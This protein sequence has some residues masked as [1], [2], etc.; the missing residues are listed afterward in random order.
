M[1]DGKKFLSRTGFY[2]GR[3]EDLQSPDGSGSEVHRQADFVRRQ[4]KRADAVRSYRHVRMHADRSGG[5]KVDD[6]KK[7]ELE[8][9]FDEAYRLAMEM[10]IER[11]RRPF[12]RL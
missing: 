1:I 11:G 5:H 12:Y 4:G 7:E 6:K 8:R 2:G 10:V 9:E 3:R